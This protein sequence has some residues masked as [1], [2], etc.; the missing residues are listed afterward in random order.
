LI[1]V[2]AY[3]TT[4]ALAFSFLAVANPSFWQPVFAYADLQYI[5]EVN[6]EL[7]GRRY[8]VYGHDWRVTPPMLWLELMAAREI[9][10]EVAS[11]PATTSE[12]LLVLSQSDFAT[13]LRDALRDF[14]NV[15]ALS[16][17]PLLRSRLILSRA[18]DASLNVR[19]ATL[20]SLLQETADSLQESPRLLKMYRALYH[21]YFQPAATQEQ[22]AELLDLPFSTYRRHLRSGIEYITERLW[23]IEMGDLDNA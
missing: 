3:L 10:R 4:P 16:N 12:P 15:N 18:G 6:F 7:D 14:A 5:A 20:R 9:G 11:A 17:N 21:T 19:V 22:A 23:T 2:Q 1:I 8:G 13:A